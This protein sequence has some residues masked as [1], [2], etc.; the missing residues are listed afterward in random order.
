MIAWLVIILL[1]SIA[2][3]ISG[4][5]IRSRLSILVGGAVPWFGLLAVL[6]YYEY[7]VP[8]SGGGASMWPV[9]QLFAGTMA[10]V[11]GTLTATIV[12]AMPRN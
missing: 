11:S 7:F 10:A 12:H 3:G 5:L 4:Y 9:A 6:L 1:S 8:Y 2:G